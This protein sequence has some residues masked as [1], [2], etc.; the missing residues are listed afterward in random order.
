MKQQFL[1]INWWVPKENFDSYYD[2]L[3]QQE[4][5]PF[6]EKF[7]SWNKTFWERLGDDWEYFRAPFQER[8]YAD[9]E[10]WKIMFEK[11]FPYLRDDIV[12]GAGSLGACFFMKYLCETTFPVKVKRIIFIAAALHDTEKER[13]GTFT[14]DKK[15]VPWIATQ[16]WEIICY[17]SKD[18]DIVPFSD[19]EVMK[20][21]FPHATFRE[22][23]DRGH[24]YK[25]AR[26]PE[27]EQDIK[28]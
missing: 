18:D 5:N 17:H 26:L 22:F 1:Y 28:S 27:I 23:T 2:F 9:Y 15:K 7:Q 20:Q 3:K 12:I 19:F 11:T 24:F 6:E 21:Y 4:Y 13:L 14:L 25:E 16:L 8:G 10:A